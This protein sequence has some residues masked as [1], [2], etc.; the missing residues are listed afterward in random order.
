[1]NTEYGRF[2]KTKYFI[3]GC[4]IAI[5]KSKNTKEEFNKGSNKLYRRDF[6]K[7]FYIEDGKGTLVI[8]GRRYPLTPGFIGLVRPDDL[9]TYEL[10]IDCHMYNILFSP[11]TFSGWLDNFPE[12]NDPLKQAMQDISFNSSLMRDQHNLLTVNRKIL[13]II[14]EMRKE[15]LRQD[16]S[17]VILLKLQLTELLLQL[18]RRSKSMSSKRRRSNLINYVISWLEENFEEN[19]DYKD[20]AKELGI[21]HIYLCSAYRQ[22]T[23]ESIGQTQL[24]IRLKNAKRL[25]VETRQSVTEVCMSCGFN[26]LSYFYR[27]FK[28]DTGIPPGTFRKQFSL[29]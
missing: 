28:K 8:N 18:H 11:D 9:S 13:S 16:E 21:T 25:L 26:D 7:I 4:P 3:P 29:F 6:W 23:G 22:E 19:F 24:R 5:L 1:M 14:H 2:T 15:F 12:H 27:A 17:S 10:D 20:A